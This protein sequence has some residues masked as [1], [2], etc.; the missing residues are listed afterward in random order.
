[1]MLRIVLLAAMLGASRAS[2]SISAI[3]T[4]TD[5][6][7]GTCGD[8]PYHGQLVT[9]ECAISA[10]K[11][12]GFYCQDAPAVWS[13]LWVYADHNDNPYWDD[14]DDIVY[15][16]GELVRV[17]GV[18][19][20]YYGVTEIDV[21]DD[22][23]NFNIT[24]LGGYDFDMI[25]PIAVDSGTLGTSCN[26]AGEA[27]EGVLVTLSDVEIMGTENQYGE[28]EIDDGTGATQLEDSLMDTHEHF[29]TSFCNLTS[30]DYVGDV[31]GSLTGVVHY[32]YSSYEVHP[33]YTADIELTIDCTDDSAAGGSNITAISA[34]QTVTDVS[35]SV[36]GDS[37][38]H[39]QLVTVECAVS[40]VTSYGFFCQDAPAVWSGL[41]VYAGDAAN[42]YWGDDV[43][44]T[45][46]EL[47][48]VTG[49]VDEYY[50][51]TEIDAGD[52]VANFAIERLGWN[53]EMIAPISV[54]TGTLG[55][56]CNLDGEAYEA[57][58]VTLSD[59]EVMGAENNYGEIEIDDGS[60]ATQLEDDLMD[61]HEHLSDAFCSVA[62]RDYVGDVITSLT[63]VVDYSYSSYEL[64]PRTTADFVLTVDCTAYDDVS[65][66]SISEIQTVTSVGSGDDCAA[67]PLLG[68]L[69]LIECAISAIDWY[70]FYCQDAPQ[71]W[72]GIY[73]Y[74]RYASGEYWDDVTYQEGEFVR[75]FGEVDE[76]N[77]LTE[78]N[79]GN[80][81][82][83]FAIT[84]L[85][86]DNAMVAPISVTTGQ[87]GIACNMVGEAYE[88]LM[89]TLANVEI[90][91]TPNQYGEIVIDD[92]SGATQLEDGLMDTHEHF[93]TAFC[94]LTDRAYVGDVMTTLTGIVRYAWSSY[95]VYPRSA[96]DIELPIDC[97]SPTP[98]PVTH[99]V[100]ATV[101]LTGL[102]CDEYTDTEEAIL[103]SALATTLSGVEEED[104]G[105]TECADA[106]RRRH[107]HLRR[108]LGS[109]DS[110]SIS[111]PITVSASSSSVAASS[112]DSALTS[113]VATGTLA[114][115]LATAAT[116]AGGDS[117][118][119]SASVDSAS[120]TADDDDGA[121]IM[122]KDDDG[123]D[124]STA[125]VTW[126]I[127]GAVVVVLVLAIGI[128][129][130]KIGMKAGASKRPTTPTTTIQ[131]ASTQQQSMPVVALHPSVASGKADAVTI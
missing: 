72:S 49:V 18:I 107:R 103:V 38:M 46:G 127:I 120:A 23:S 25:A 31:I 12:N 28:I 128:V 32:S 33:R 75:I 10:V 74:A 113:A 96:A 42:E 91:S 125:M 36:C 7:S 65:V 68:Q 79:A 66:T 123:D 73:I 70:G 27:Y 130:F 115:N 17:T 111:F 112:I 58:L 15:D 95:E 43:T 87:L 81:V 3:Q 104:I 51:L 71:V 60:G 77:G 78:L 116:A 129:A 114:A 62:G 105:D 59:V 63:G 97:G 35:G 11:Y 99:A 48:R 94:N 85:G 44:Y 2:M 26:F 89:V 47:V 9:V 16:I 34:I 4:V 82:A 20:E 124:A 22:V 55:T 52:D 109:T 92:G 93:T 50:D 53:Y 6:S 14:G 45:V 21:T 118:I 19:D 61:T 69:V 90:Q 67:S 80:D 122:V 126:V 37:P 102:S 1:M 106:R 131:V 84:R 56:S 64:H 83:A 40:A 100:T 5:V 108:L 101:G 29:S 121:D 30:R 8:S 98:A 57:L 88:G 41:Y 76:Y 54:A 86:Y 24:R 117:V 13:G 110:V 39:G 119:G